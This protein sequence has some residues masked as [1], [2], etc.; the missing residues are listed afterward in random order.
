MPGGPSFLMNAESEEVLAKLSVSFI[1]RG[2]V[3]A[4]FFD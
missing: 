1:F 3:K 4:V 2:G